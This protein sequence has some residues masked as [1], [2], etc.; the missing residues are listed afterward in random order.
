MT[1]TREIKKLDKRNIED[2][3]AL[4]PTQEG[5]LFHYLKDPESEAYHEQLSLE[6]TGNIDIKCFQ[7]AWNF[8]IET[9]EMLRTVY[10][11]ENMANPVQVVL[12]KHQLQVEYFDF[13]G[14]DRNGRKKV[15]EAMKRKDR[16]KK[17]NLEDV[18]F[19]VTLYK[20]DTNRY[21]MI[22]SNHH[23][24]YDGWSNGIILGEFFNAYHDLAE[25]KPL[26]PLLKTK[27][28]EFVKWLRCQETTKQE[29]FW[30]EYLQDFN[31]RIEGNYPARRYKR[32]EITGTGNHLIKLP[33]EMKDKLTDFARSRNLTFASLL[34]T[35]WGI[36]LQHYNST[37]DVLFD[38][39]VSG[40][41]A[42]VREIENMVGLFINT[43]P[44]RMQT[45]PGEKLSNLVSRMHHM[46][47]KREIFENSSPIGIN[48]HLHDYH[49]QHLFDSVIILENYPLDRI[50]IQ[51]NGPLT[52]NAFYISE[53]THYDLT[54]IVT[55]FGDIKVTVT[56]NKDRFDRDS[57]LRL[58]N[59]FTAIFREV[60]EN[61]NKTIDQLE[62]LPEQ[63][64]KRILSSPGN[65]MKV[66]IAAESKSR[67]SVCQEIPYIS[68][69]AFPTDDM[70]K[71]L[72]RIW[73]EVLG[74]KPGPEDDFFEI[75][76]SSLQLVR[77][78]KQINERYPGKIKV[79]D[80]FA[81]PTIRKLKQLLI[82][83]DV[84]HVGT[85]AKKKKIKNIN[86]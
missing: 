30:K 21:E 73:E 71:G 79:N 69:Q 62:P 63:E 56:Y 36:L 45:N 33:A 39:T 10:R 29:A 5:M 60:L 18:T 34:Y 77:I 12:K 43:L 52:V 1:V 22:I 7:A 26:K 85:I 72:V 59:H 35:V 70:E 83:K 44:L 41:S 8:V 64:K 80:F 48:E 49:N 3:I 4:T 53:I 17:F 68:T 81:H 66:N 38:T 6:I 2:I 50:L 65:Q 25:G 57:M 28:K 76:G 9:N 32:K 67:E 11:W 27:F 13:L 78:Y 31:I 51:E 84:Y 16:E 82:S 75:G 23:I 47:Q 46:L 58:D 55:I 40:R 61:P 15:V 74:K 24:L 86:F 14:K 54:V 42:K 20:V 37:D 19:R